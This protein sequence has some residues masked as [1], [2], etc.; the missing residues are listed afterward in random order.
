MLRELIGLY[1]ASIVNKLT[2]QCAF[3][4]TLIFNEGWLLRAVLQE[5][6]NNSRASQFGFLPFPGDATYYSEGQ[7]RTPFRARIPGHGLAESHSHVDGIVGHFSIEGTKSGI[8][9][10]PGFRYLAVFEA[11][12]FSPLAQGTRNAPDYDQASRIVACLIHNVLQTEAR[13]GYRAYFVILYAQDNR[14]VRPDQYDKDH[15]A[16][17][18]DRRLR[19]YQ[20]AGSANGAIALFATGWKQVLENLQVWLA[21][22]EQVLAE[23]GD[24]ELSEFYERCKQFNSYPTAP[25]SR[26]KIGASP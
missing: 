7:L 17:Q 19:A 26:R 13:P 21:T 20:E 2:P 11:K 8:E 10:E 25:R 16:D 18:I 22:W 4:E 15:L 5:W 12:M 23:M 1:Q 6:R 3:P 24:D 14:Y 9:L